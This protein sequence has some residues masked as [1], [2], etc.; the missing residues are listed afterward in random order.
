[1]KNDTVLNPNFEIKQKRQI[2]I[3]LLERERERERER[4]EER[5]ERSVIM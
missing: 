5:G 2:I 1:L 4:R 3:S